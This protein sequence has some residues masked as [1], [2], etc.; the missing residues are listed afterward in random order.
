ML[1]WQGWPP[2]QLGT[3][4]QHHN[5]KV[6]RL[7]FSQEALQFQRANFEQPGEVSQARGSCKCGC[8]PSLSTESVGPKWKDV[9]TED[10]CTLNS[11]LPI[12]SS[13]FDGLCSPTDSHSDVTELLPPS[14]TLTPLSL[15]GPRQWQTT[16]AESRQSLASIYTSLNFNI[17]GYPAVGP[18][19]LTPTIPSIAGSHHVSST[20]PSGMFNSR[21]SSPHLTVDQANDI[22][23]L[24]A[25][26][27][28]LG[29]KL[30]KEFQVLS[31]LE[32]MHCNSIQGTVHETLTLGCSAQEAAYLAILRD[33]VSE[34]ECEAMT[35]CLHS[36]ADAARKE[37]HEV[38]YNHQLH[39]NWQLSAFLTDMETTLNN[40]RDEVWATI[41][42]LAENDGIMFDACLGLTLQVLNLLL[43]IPI[44]ISFQTQI[45]LTITYCPESSVCKRWC[46][47]QG[48]VSPLCKEVRASCTLSKVLGGVTRQPSEGVDHPPSPAAS[49][50]SAGSGRLQGSRG[51]SCS[52]ALSITPAHSWRS[53]SVGSVAG[54]HSVRSHTTKGSE[55]SSSES[56]LSHNEEDAASEDENAEADKGGVETS[57][58]GQVA[59]DGEEGQVHPQTQDTL[60][61]ISQVFGTHEDTN[62][63]SNPREKIQSIW[64]KWYQTSPKE[65]SPPRNPAN[66]LLRRSCPQTRHSTMRP[67]KELGSW[68]RFNAWHHKKIAKGVIG[69][70]T[71]DTMICDLPEHRKTQLNHPDPMG[72]PLDY[73]GEC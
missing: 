33:E 23:K 31:G 34:A 47:E 30:A 43:Q 55:E 16:L 14:I 37:M 46:P 25:E 71:R 17:P 22:F 61:S 10:S 12:S 9:R 20:W 8:F 15:A 24:A 13:V 67:G 60:N 48:S 73:M 5:S 68:T 19:N 54:H 57:S 51:Q 1:Q 21:T 44:D 4:L 36:E 35:H 40:M 49:D 6:P 39:Y 56:E 2:P 59:S 69:W 41:C 70:A 52:C 11:T 3:Q 72:L 18:G 58:D 7:H 65:D 27:Q 50:N 66:H 29:I 62:P 28:A 32:A 26:C 42:A 53:G 63:E 45:P 38:M 64:Q